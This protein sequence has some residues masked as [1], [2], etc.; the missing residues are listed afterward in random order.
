MTVAAIAY[1]ELTPAARAGTARL[2]ALNP[3][4][5]RWIAHYPPGQQQEVAFLEA[6]RWPDAIKHEPGYRNDGERPHGLAA[7][8]NIGYADHLQHRYWH[9]I[10]QPLAIEGADAPPA[11]QPNALTQIALFRAT[12]RSASASDAL[13]SYDLVWLLHLVADVHQPLHAV[14]RFSP[15]QPRGDAGGNRVRLCAPPCRLELHAFWDEAL[16]KS[17]KPEAA[18]RLAARLPAAPRALGAQSDPAVWARESFELARSAVY[19]DPI[20][21]GAGPYPLTPAYKAR[22]RRIA[23]ERIA[24]AGARLARLLNDA[25]H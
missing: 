2:L 15:A 13:K 25:F 19:V 6:A 7:G 3:D 11:A 1:A 14:T 10:D 4:Y 21:D 5:A 22:A 24:L 16:G 9:F 18:L 20:G 12:L 23:R 8:R 17:R